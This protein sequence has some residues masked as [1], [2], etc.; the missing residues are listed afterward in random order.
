M[1]CLSIIC[2]DCTKTFP[3]KDEKEAYSEAISYLANIA[4]SRKT[5]REI[6]DVFSPNKFEVI[7]IKTK[8]DVD[9][10]LKYMN[11][12]SDDIKKVISK[13]RS[14]FDQQ[15]IPRIYQRMLC[16]YI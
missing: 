15:N 10:F 5:E 7:P 2:I 14:I 11:N 12:T 4:F 13:F 16:L 9:M 3:H 1:I 8:Y 6:K